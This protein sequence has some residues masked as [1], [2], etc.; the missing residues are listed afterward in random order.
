VHPTSN[1]IAYP[2]VQRP[3]TSTAGLRAYIYTR[4]FKT[5]TPQ[6]RE[7]V[8]EWMNGQGGVGDFSEVRR[9]WIK[10]LKFYCKIIGI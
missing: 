7:G 9:G 2:S 4:Y 1:S 6:R 8:D 10:G 5:S 3:E